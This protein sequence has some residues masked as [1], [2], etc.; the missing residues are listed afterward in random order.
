MLYK[1]SVTFTI[2]LYS[3]YLIIYFIMHVT[4]LLSKFDSYIIILLNFPF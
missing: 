1:S 4:H 3:K 2:K